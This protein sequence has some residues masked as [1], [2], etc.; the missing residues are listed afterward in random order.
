MSFKASLRAPSKA[1]A[2]FSM[3]K[4][5]AGGCSLCQS[6]RSLGLD[7]R[8]QL[9]QWNAPGDE[10][11]SSARRPQLHPVEHLVDLPAVGGSVKAITIVPGATN[12]PSPYVSFSGYEWRTRAH[13]ASAAETLNQYA[14]A[15]AWTDAKDALHLQIT[16]VLKIGSA[17]RFL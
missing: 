3:R 6:S 9:Y 15:N 8:F 2:W 14:S 12:S 7:Q 1:I 13:Q 11:C 16:G 10:I 5:E 4:P 17:R